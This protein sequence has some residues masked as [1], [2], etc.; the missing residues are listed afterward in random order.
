MSSRLRYFILLTFLGFLNLFAQVNDI[1]IIAIGGKTVDRNGP[2]SIITLTSECPTTSYTLSVDIFN[3]SAGALAI[4]GVDGTLTIT[5]SITGS[6]SPTVVP[7]Q[8][9]IL[10]LASGVSSTIDFTFDLSSAGASAFTVSLTGTLVDGESGVGLNDNDAYANINV[11]NVPDLAALNSD[12]GTN[13]CEG[14]FV[15]ISSSGGSTYQFFINGA[16]MTLNPTADSSFKTSSLSD[17]D[18]VSVDVVYASGC[19]ATNS[20][21]FS[22]SPTPNSQ[23]GGTLVDVNPTAASD[24][25]VSTEKQVDHITITNSALGDGEKYFVNL[26]GTEFTYNTVLADGYSNNDIASEIA[27]LLL[28]DPEIGTAVVNTIGT[29]S[30][31]VVTAQNPGSTYDI[32]V[33]SLSANATI[34][35]NRITAAKTITVC[36]GTSELT[37][38]GPT[39]VTSWTYYLNGVLADGITLTHLNSI[40]TT[41]TLTNPGSPSLLRLV[42]QNTFTC[43]SDI[44]VNIEVN[45]ITDPGVITGTQ[46]ICL[47]QVPAVI[48]STSPATASDSDATVSYSW[49]YKT[50]GD[51][52]E[53]NPKITTASYTPA[54]LT[55]TTLLRRQSI[56]DLN[57]MECSDYR[58]P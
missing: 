38:T 45:E 24:G 37:A 55:T 4:G 20:L 51:W 3:E 47:G 23:G 50:N 53:F 58:T 56:S 12:Q 43:S 15:R 11:F 2:P 1:S 30:T 36:S 35:T 19:S 17:G 41:A 52:E 54:A 26:N 34:G 57:G 13:I 21:T 29:N 22:V 49:Y 10:N 16:P 40:T 9:V 31:I 25:F 33:S 18:I 6:N 32:S 46:T 39:S 7:S 8:N 5:V 27:S 14:E 42:G 28:T 44:Y 48:N